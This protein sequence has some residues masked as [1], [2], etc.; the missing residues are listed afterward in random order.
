[1]VWESHEDQKVEETNFS[2][3]NHVIVA[4]VDHRV[5]R[6]VYLKN[7]DLKF[8]LNDVEGTMVPIA[9]DWLELTCLVQSDDDKPCNITGS[10]VFMIDFIVS[11]H[12]CSLCAVT[13][14][15]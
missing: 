15:G 11:S 10:Q 4:E 3:I 13:A 14:I 9:G 2:I 12:L 1:M 7:N 6:L 8:S 5:E